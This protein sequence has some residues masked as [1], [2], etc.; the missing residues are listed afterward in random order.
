M[1]KKVI[2]I[3]TVIL[4]L[5][6]G[7]GIFAGNF[8]YELGISRNGNRDIVF[9]A[10]HNQ[11][12][13]VMSEALAQIEMPAVPLAEWLQTITLKQTFLTSADSL[14][15]SAYIIRNEIRSDKWVIIAHGYTAA[16]DDMLESARSFYELGFNVLLPDARGHGQSEGDY[17]GMGWHERLDML[18]WI[19]KLTEEDDEIEI[20]LYGV[21]M[22]ATTVMMT[23]GEELPDNVKAVVE[24]CGYTSVNEEFS[25]QLEQIFDLPSFPIINF[26]SLVTK[27]RAGY[28]F[29]EADAIKQ[30]RKAKV[31]IL[32]IHGDQDTFVPPYMLDQAYEAAAAEKEKLL[33]EGAGHGLSSYIA[34]DLYWTKVKE[35]IG[36]YIED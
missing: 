2:I 21:S 29:R 30:L 7:A 27:I 36:K 19:A 18:K 33:I 22:G 23:A 35:F 6:M 28:T 5:F 10:E 17:F 31:P 12:S 25:Y 15:L 13:E 16:A 11:V 1:R 9:E 32:F 14:K 34:R 4:V 3:L 24:D 26:A 8:F 20:V